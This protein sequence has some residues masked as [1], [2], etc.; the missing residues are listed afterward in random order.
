MLTTL[1]HHHDVADEWDRL[2]HHIRGL[3]GFDRFLLPWTFTQLQIA[4]HDGPVILINISTHHCDALILMPNLD[5]ILHI[6]SLSRLLRCF[7]I[8]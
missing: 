1:E 5:D 4:T 7:L 2:V 8:V 3:E 6:P